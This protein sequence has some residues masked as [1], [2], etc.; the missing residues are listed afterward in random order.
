MLL[1]MVRSSFPNT[2]LASL[3]SHVQAVDGSVRRLNILREIW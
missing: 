2:L 3:Y 1:H